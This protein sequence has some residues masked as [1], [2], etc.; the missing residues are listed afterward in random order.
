[1]DNANALVVAKHADVGLRDERGCSMLH[2]V[3]IL[4]GNQGGFRKDH[5][6]IVTAA[7]VTSPFCDCYFSLNIVDIKLII[8][9][10][11]KLKIW[12]MHVKYDL[13]VVDRLQ[14]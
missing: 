11:I 10:N 4:S 12:F 1:M 6:T 9:I 2:K 8:L 5:V 3:D 13:N 7:Q 14:I